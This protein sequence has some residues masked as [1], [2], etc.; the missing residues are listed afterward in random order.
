MITSSPGITFCI[1]AF[2]G[3]AGASGSKYEQCIKNRLVIARCYLN[4]HSQFVLHLLSFF[5]FAFFFIFTM[6]IC[7][8]MHI[9]AHIS[10][11]MRAYARKCFLF[12]LFPI[13]V[14]SG[15]KIGGGD[16]QIEESNCGSLRNRKN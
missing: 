15:Y 2:W 10:A 13:L 14:S 11:L 16:S 12:S 7:I 4:I 8:Y 3:N 9:Y 6:C 5:V 1:L